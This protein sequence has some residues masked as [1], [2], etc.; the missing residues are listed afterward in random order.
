MC[1]WEYLYFKEGSLKSVFKIEFQWNNHKQQW[2]RHLSGWAPKTCSCSSLISDSQITQQLN[3]TPNWIWC[4]F[5]VLGYCNLRPCFYHI[6]TGVDFVII[7]VDWKLNAIK[8]II[9]SVQW[10]DQENRLGFF[11]YNIPDTSRS[12]CKIKIFYGCGFIEKLILQHTYAY[13]HIPY[14]YISRS[15][16]EIMIS[17][18]WGF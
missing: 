5:L 6:S 12:F 9:D 10:I 8:A 15:F 11:L 4:E 14:Q 7:P 2:H 1:G 16:C 17:C 3:S 13:N 18:G